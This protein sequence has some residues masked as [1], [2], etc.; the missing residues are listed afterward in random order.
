MYRMPAQLQLA[1]WYP[2]RNGRTVKLAA[3]YRVD[4]GGTAAAVRALAVL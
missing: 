2:V 1:S 4:Q 3:F